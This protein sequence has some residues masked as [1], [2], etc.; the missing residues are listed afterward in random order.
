MF[1][2]LDVRAEAD[3]SLKPKCLS[4]S[5]IDVKEIRRNATD[6]PPG[7]WLER[8]SFRRTSHRSP[9]D[10]SLACWLL[11]QI[12]PLTHKCESSK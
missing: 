11:I 2:V 10:K 8:A 5:A 12:F 7:S 3:I 9:D 4:S 1:D 6:L